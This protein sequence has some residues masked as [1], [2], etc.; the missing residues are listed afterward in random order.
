[1]P[2]LGGGPSAGWLLE[3]RPLVIGQAP[4]YLFLG[5]ATALGIRIR[6]PWHGVRDTK[7]THE[8]VRETPHPVLRVKSIQPVAASL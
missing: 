8:V 6:S 7:G 4:N 2:A 5:S 1:M 3:S